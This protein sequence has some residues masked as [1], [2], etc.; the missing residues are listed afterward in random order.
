MVEYLKYNAGWILFWFCL[1]GW[2]IMIFFIIRSFVKGDI[3]N[4]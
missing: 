4:E 2:L 1:I 3:D